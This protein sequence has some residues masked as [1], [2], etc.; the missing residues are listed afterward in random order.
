ML[1]YLNEG[2]RFPVYDVL[3]PG[4]S[5]T[6]THKTHTIKHGQ[7][8]STDYCLQTD[9]A[10]KVDSAADFACTLELYLL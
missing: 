4:S 7:T 9:L 3:V 1:I 10:E 5:E 6:Q 2:N 8:K